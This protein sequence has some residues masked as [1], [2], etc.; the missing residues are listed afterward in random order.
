MSSNIVTQTSLW[1][2][3]LGFRSILPISLQ[4]IEWEKIYALHSNELDK[5]YTL[6]PV[7]FFIDQYRG[8]QFK[9]PRFFKNFP[10]FAHLW[11]LNTDISL[12][13]DNDLRKWF[14]TII[15][16]PETLWSVDIKNYIP[17][18]KIQKNEKNPNSDVFINFDNQKIA[19][20]K[21]I[22]FMDT[23]QY[24]SECLTNLVF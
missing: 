11:N 14:Y 18:L 8:K 16:G 10:D 4:Q 23:H 2:K 12:K 13:L 20:E 7:S 21:W 19:D 17:Q 15:K 6:I 9:T 3:Q 1:G 5:G 24:I 22:D